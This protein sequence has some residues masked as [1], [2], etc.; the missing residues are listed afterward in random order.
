MRQ[1]VGSRVG[2]KAAGGIRTTDQALQ[3]VEAGAN[4]IGTSSSLSILEGMT[5]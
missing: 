2:V 5:R 3:M 4:R 1:I